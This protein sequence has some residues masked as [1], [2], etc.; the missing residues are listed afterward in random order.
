MR[1]RLDELIA[2][3]KKSTELQGEINGSLRCKQ[4]YKFYHDLRRATCNVGLEGL[5][6][7]L[8][9][10]AI[11][12][13]LFT[14]LVW[15]N[16]HTWIY[17]KHKGKYV[18]VEDQDPYMP[19]STIDRGGRGGSM[20]A[21]VYQRSRNIHTPPQTPPYH[22]TL[23]G[24]S[25]HGHIMPSKNGSM[26]MGG[27]MGGMPMGAGP[28]GMSMEQKPLP[29]PP[30]LHA[31]VGYGHIGTL[32]GGMGHG[33]SAGPHPLGPQGFMNPGHA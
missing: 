9:S 12:A 2:S 15:C 6:V 27:S 24:H 13:I 11:S 8:V 29:G 17:F 3:S 28:N 19:L 30:T 14:I 4:I 21:P 25:Q 32:S 31:G 7:M 5:L 26:Q 33:H 22:G 10:A 23:N 20:G 16:S 1:P 18:K